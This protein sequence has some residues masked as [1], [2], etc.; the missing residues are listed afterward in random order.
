M[1]LK[2]YYTTGASVCVVH[3]QE[4]KTSVIYEANRDFPG[5]VPA[6]LKKSGFLMNGM[7]KRGRPL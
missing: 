4:A 3:W 7:P 5:V 6:R 1:R 2:E